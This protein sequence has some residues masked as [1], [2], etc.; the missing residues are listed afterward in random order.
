MALSRR[1]GTSLVRVGGLG[2]STSGWRPKHDGLALDSERQRSRCQLTASEQLCSDACLRMSAY[3]S[4]A[5][6]P[7]TWPEPTRI[8][9]CGR[10][11]FGKD[12]LTLMQCWSVLPCVRPVVRRLSLAAGHNA[13]RR[14]GPG[15]KHA[16]SPTPYHANLG[17]TGQTKETT[18]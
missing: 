1:S 8:A 11:P 14:S 15:Q 2:R 13:L 3:G 18:P 4:K 5:V 16:T 7:D 10:L 12:F 17:A 6:V 9:M